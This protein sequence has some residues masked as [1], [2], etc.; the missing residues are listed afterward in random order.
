[1][2]RNIQLV[3][4]AVL[5]S[6]FALSAC[7]GGIIPPSDQSLEDPGNPV[8]SVDNHAE[9]A[10][11]AESNT[12]SQDNG[13]INS[14]GTIVA[15]MPDSGGDPGQEPGS[16]PEG[17][18]GEPPVGADNVNWLT[19]A[20][21]EFRFSIKYPDIFVILDEPKQ[22][23]GN[24]PE[25]IHRV[26]F[27]DK[28]LLGV[29]TAALEPPQFSIEVFSNSAG[30]SLQEWLQQREMI[31]TN[32]QVEDFLIAGQPGLIVTRMEL[33]APG[34]FVFIEDKGLVFRLTPLG[35]YSEE[36]LRS[37]QFTN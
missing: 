2:K 6:I 17:E 37:F 9:Q 24:V 10:M 28:S 34:Q 33:I 31:P 23:E 35:S 22:P 3:T 26:R 21:S 32:S 4:T 30:L 19:Y 15:P 36:M 27:Q 12:S 16:L 20:D 29:D 5:Y 25:L 8:N 13:V 7:S 14:E 11:T 1:M 18:S